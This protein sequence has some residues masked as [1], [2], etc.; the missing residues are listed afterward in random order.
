MQYAMLRKWD[1]SKQFLLDNR[2]LC[3]EDTANY[4]TIECLNN[5]MEGVNYFGR[6]D[7]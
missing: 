1:D 3:C 5:E 2:H 7:G 4:L 6:M